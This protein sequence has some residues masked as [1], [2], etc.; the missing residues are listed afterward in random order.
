M[1]MQVVMDPHRTLIDL[2][3]GNLRAFELFKRCSFRLLALTNANVAGNEGSRRRDDL[4]GSNL[5][6]LQS[7]L[8]FLPPP[9]PKK[10]R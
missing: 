4:I 5:Q 10:E 2:K 9:L 8:L 7:L 3:E 6:L 1:M